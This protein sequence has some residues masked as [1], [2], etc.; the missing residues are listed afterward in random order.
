MS[1]AGLAG[2]VRRE[3]NC[4]RERVRSWRAQAVGEEEREGGGE[5]VVGAGKGA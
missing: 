2:A 5:A 4:R 3:Q 1:L